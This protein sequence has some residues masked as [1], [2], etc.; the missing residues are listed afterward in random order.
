MLK[1]NDENQ[2]T[3]NLDRKKIKDAKI[4][5]GFD[6]NYAKANFSGGLKDILINSV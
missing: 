1:V 4:M 2:G 3:L 5:L 6:S